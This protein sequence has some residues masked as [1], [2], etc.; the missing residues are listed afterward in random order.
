MWGKPAVEGDVA[1]VRYKPAIFYSAKPPLIPGDKAAF[2][3]WAGSDR[4]RCTVPGAIDWVGQVIP[5]CQTVMVSGSA[6][7]EIAAQEALC[8]FTGCRQVSPQEI[9]IVR[10][11][12][13]PA[14]PQ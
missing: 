5:V 1:R 12:K 3:L 14:D 2:A 8:F 7:D 11:I 13:L 6:Q 9:R 4:E 10:H